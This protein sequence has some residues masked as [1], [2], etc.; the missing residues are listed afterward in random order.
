[1]A[2][3]LLKGKRGI[4]MGVANE[5]SI[6]WAV[7]E[8]CREQGAE[9]AFS[10]LGDAQEKRLRH[11]TTEWTHT[12][13][14]QC[15]VSQD[16]SL[17]EFF[18]NISRQCDSIDFV[19][20]SIAHTDKDCLRNP[21]TETSREQFL[22][23]LDVSAFSLVAVAKRSIPLLKN[24]G[25]ILSMSYLGSE[26]VL[27]GYNVM[28]VA[29]AALE[30]STRY[31]ADDLGKKN[32][33]VNCISAGPIRTLSASAIG[34]I[35]DIIASSAEKS[36]LRRAVTA[37]DVAKSSVFLLSDMASGITGEVIHVDCGFGILAA[38]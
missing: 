35:K 3:N 7:A 15:N 13:L 38:T 23:T 29:K 9:I 16:A 28:G 36:P 32:I 26:K 30:C 2:E 19:V 20:H 8:K 25:S 17:D 24:G 27:P 18:A 1:M 37:E 11:L 33:R 5:H 4:I 6:A 10:Y 34:G 22:Y 12:T 14:H 21:F 31:L